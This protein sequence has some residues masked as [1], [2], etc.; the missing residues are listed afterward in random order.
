VDTPAPGSGVSAGDRGSPGGDLVIG[1][2]DDITAPGAIK[3]GER[4]LLPRME[5]NLGSPKANW[6]RNESLLRLEMRRG[7]PIRDGS[8]ARPDTELAPTDLNASRT[9][10]QTFTG[11]ERNVLRNHGWTFDGTYW[12]PPAPAP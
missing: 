9:I 4:T 7:L 6:G 5:E 11:L 12:N 3:P 10:R 8:A 2:L 1:R